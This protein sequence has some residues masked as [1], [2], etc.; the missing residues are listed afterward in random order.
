MTETRPTEE[1][2]DEIDRC[3]IALIER[4]NG[5]CAALRNNGIDIPHD[6]ITFSQGRSQEEALTIQAVLG[7][8]KEEILNLSVLAENSI[9]AFIV[10]TYLNEKI[11]LPYNCHTSYP[12]TYFKRLVA[13]MKVINQRMLLTPINGRTSLDEL[14]QHVEK[15]V[16]TQ[17]IPNEYGFD[18]YEFTIDFDPLEYLFEQYVATCKSQ[19]VTLGTDYSMT[20]FRTHI[21]LD[22]DDYYD[23]LGTSIVMHIEDM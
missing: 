10:A 16:I 4:T 17:S 6:D 14:Q 1:P 12:R 3:L 15:T 19:N 7:V 2:I 23:A 13:F 22:D 18:D 5:V 21:N 8:P 20:Q 9:R 11:P